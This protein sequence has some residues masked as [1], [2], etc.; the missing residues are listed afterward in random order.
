ME[1]MGGYRRRHGF[2]GSRRVKATPSM[3][4]DCRR[5]P[6]SGR[7]RMISENACW[8]KLFCFFASPTVPITV[9][10]YSPSYPSLQN[11]VINHRPMVHLFNTI[12]IS[13]FQ[14]HFQNE[15]WSS[16]MAGKP[17]GKHH[18]SNF[19][20]RKCSASIPRR[21]SCSQ[22]E[23]TIIGALHSCTKRVLRSRQDVW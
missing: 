16:L 3:F 12:V 17:Q 8:I 15:Q 13:G 7:P 4:R 11:I 23:I 5:R 22:N 2:G 18:T 6:E 20:Y 9:K 10:H 14:I 21:L 19:P 1:T